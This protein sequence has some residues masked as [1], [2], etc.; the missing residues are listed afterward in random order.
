MVE[1]AEALGANVILSM[2]FD[3]SELSNFI[4]EVV[5]RQRPTRSSL[6]GT[7][8]IT[9]DRFGER[10]RGDGP[11][12]KSTLPGRGIGRADTRDQDSRQRRADDVSQCEAWDL[13]PVSRASA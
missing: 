11:V 3:A 8:F 12:E 6:P 5:D 2:R 4:T 7:G 9:H 10:A 1:K 13:C